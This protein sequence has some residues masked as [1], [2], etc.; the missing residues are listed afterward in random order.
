M[1]MAVLL[2]VMEELG[3]KGPAVGQARAKLLDWQLANPT[4]DETE[5]LQWLRKEGQSLL[6]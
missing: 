6:Q 3:A 2:Q 1:V 5:A 4:A